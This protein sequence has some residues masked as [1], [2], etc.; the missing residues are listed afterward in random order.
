MTSLDGYSLN[1]KMDDKLEEINERIDAVHYRI[2]QEMEYIKTHFQ[3]L[4]KASSKKKEKKD[5]VSESV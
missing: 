3:E 4:T 5:A 1:K 2:E